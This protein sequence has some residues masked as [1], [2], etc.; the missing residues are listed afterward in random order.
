MWI[1][2][3]ACLAV[4]IAQPFDQY[5]GRWTAEYHGTTYVRLVLGSTSDGAPQGVMSIG[6]SIHVDARGE[7]DGATEAPAP[8][9]PMLNLRWNGTVLSFSVERG[10][11]IRRFEFRPIDATTGEL[12]PIIS[13][14]QR[15]ELA[16]DGIAPP[17]PFR[18][19]KA[20]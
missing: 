9:T 11:D 17:K 13:E 16:D 1:L 3:M 2:A 7:V 20:R 5:S 18:V 19:K 4:T 14:E 6:E 8:P 12:T 10:D 15:R